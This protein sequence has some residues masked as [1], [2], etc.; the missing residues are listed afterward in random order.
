[1]NVGTISESSEYE[2]IIDGTKKRVGRVNSEFVD[3]SLRVDD[4]FV[5]GSTAWRVAGVRKN[6]LLVKEAPG[7]T[8]TV[9]CR[10]G[11][12]RPRLPHGRPRVDVPSAARRN[13][14]GADADGSRDVPALL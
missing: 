12:P 1:M 5:L 10:S 3:D 13:G 6:Q 11:P 14:L 9:P 8:P 7:A 4:V 2:V